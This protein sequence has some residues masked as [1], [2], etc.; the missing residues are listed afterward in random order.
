MA[1]GISVY[2]VDDIS[3]VGVN[4]KVLD[5]VSGSEPIV[6]A[7]RVC[8][9]YTVF[10]RDVGI[11]SIY[12]SERKVLTMYDFNHI[13]TL[14]LS[15]NT[16]QDENLRSYAGSAFFRGDVIYVPA[17]VVCEIFELNYS[18]LYSDTEIVR[19]YNDEAKLS[20]DVFKT[21]V[22]ATYANMFTSGNQ[23]GSST[24]TPTTTNPTTRPATSTEEEIDD[25]LTVKVIKPTLI[26]TTT[27]D[28]ID[29]FE[30]GSLTFFAD[31]TTFED[32]ELLRYLYIKNNAI[33]IYV[34][35]DEE[36]VWAY[37]NQINAQ[38]FKTLG[39][40]TR[41]L[42]VE[43]DEYIEELESEGYIII[44]DDYRYYSS[45][46]ITNST[47]TELVIDITE[48]DNLSSFLLFCDE[49]KISFI[50]IDEFNY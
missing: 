49:E 34:S 7:G 33:G 18:L 31:Q 1:L 24:S 21:L 8:I 27:K 13:V 17:Q 2:A 16:I 4:D 28:V 19:I 46:Q 43:N 11:S 15:S 3:L 30:E 39:V 37:V 14:D 42:F 45:Y 40:K 47:K 10:S 22:D 26:S 36:D 23:S 48:E 12:S 41:F 38:L 9:P 32:A 50:K 20:N 35:Q 5:Y 25:S 44:E 6:F 29:L